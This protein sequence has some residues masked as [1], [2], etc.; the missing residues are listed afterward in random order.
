MR[1][2]AGAARADEGHAP[3]GGQ[4]EV[5]PVEH[6]RAVPVRQT[7]ALERQRRGGPD[8]QRAVRVPDRGR[9]LG[10]LLDPAGRGDD[11]RQPARGVGQRRHGLDRGERHEGQRGEHHAVEAAV[12]HRR[13]ADRQH[14][15]GRQAGERGDRRAA[16]GGDGGVPAGGA[17]QRAVGRPHAGQVAVRQAVGRDLGR[18]LHR[19]EHLRRERGAGGRLAPAG[20][21]SRERGAGGQDDGRRAEDQEQEH[22]GRR[23]DREGRARGTGGHA[24]GDEWRPEAAHVEVLQL[25][26]VGDEAAEQVAAAH[27][28]QAA[29]DE[30]HQPREDGPA[31]R[32]QDP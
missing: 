12:V 32:R 29:G 2:L 19:L 31:G 18:G 11:R 6:R 24:R 23:V 17:R 25:V 14:R 26:D 20:A 13:R 3:P 1:R 30:R 27:S 10:D 7:R 21:P 16:Q 9:R 22:A 15:G 8:G 5:D 28:G 4:A